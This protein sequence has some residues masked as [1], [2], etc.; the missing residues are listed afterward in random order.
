MATE[1]AWPA[2]QAASRR[3]RNARGGARA[4]SH[5]ARLRQLPRPRATVSLKK[6]AGGVERQ[7][8]QR[9]IIREELD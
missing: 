4:A 9:R 8:R 2:A 6:T 7:E 1:S 5:A 3:D